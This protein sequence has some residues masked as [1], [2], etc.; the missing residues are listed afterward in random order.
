[1]ITFANK[2]N[3]IPKIGFAKLQKSHA[4]IKKQTDN[5]HS[6]SYVQTQFSQEFQTCQRA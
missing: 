2:N 6:K 4:I 5:Y 3:S 1:M